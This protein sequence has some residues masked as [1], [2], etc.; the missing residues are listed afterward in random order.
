MTYANLYAYNQEIQNMKGSVLEKF[1]RGKIDEFYKHNGL[2]INT[3]LEKLRHISAD[4]FEMTEDEKQIKTIDK[5]GVKTPVMLE[6]KT[7]EDY[8]AKV[9]EYLAKEVPIAI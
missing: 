8:N 4:F 9:N 3:M 5:D 7:T 2:R 1:F 6:G